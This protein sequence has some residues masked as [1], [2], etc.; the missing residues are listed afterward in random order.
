MRSIDSSFLDIFGN[1]YTNIFEWD[2]LRDGLPNIFVGIF[3]I[4]LVVLFFVQKSI[5]LRSKLL[6]G[7]LI[8]IFILSFNI[9]AFDLA[10]QGFT[11]PNWFTHRYAFIFSFVLI[12][13]AMESFQVL[14]KSKPPIIRYSITGIAMLVVTVLLSYYTGRFHSTLKY[15]LLDIG[16]IIIFFV[17]LYFV[18]LQNR[19]WIQIVLT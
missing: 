1:L 13:I 9:V 14:R 8:V 15:A 7:G 2:D 5:N 4:V 10:W 18:H 16:L 3:V 6:A 12:I 17:L 11:P 19:I